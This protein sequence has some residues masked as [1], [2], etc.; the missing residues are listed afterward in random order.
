MRHCSENKHNVIERGKKKV[1]TP[2]MFKKFRSSIF[3]APTLAGNCPL[4][5]FN[6]AG[7]LK[8]EINYVEYDDNSKAFTCLDK[9]TSRRKPSASFCTHFYSFCIFYRS[10]S[11]AVRY[12][13]K[14]TNYIRTVY[15]RV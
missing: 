8:I 12:M 15:I 6:K 3:L 14:Y 10:D 13:S 7:S 5:E 4:S 2:C 11:T 1:F 9:R